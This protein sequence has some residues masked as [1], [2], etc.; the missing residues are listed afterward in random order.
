[1]SVDRDDRFIWNIEQATGNQL[2]AS[3]TNCDICKHYHGLSECD[4]FPDGIPEDIL[5]R[6]HDHA[7]PYPGDGGIQFEAIEER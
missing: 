7:E 1:M 6:E 3:F 5:T 2:R 4:A